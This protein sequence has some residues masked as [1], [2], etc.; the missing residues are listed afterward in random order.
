[1]LDEKGGI[2]TRLV[3]LH[4][5]ERDKVLRGQSIDEWIRLFNVKTQELDMLRM[6]TEN[7]GI[8]EVIDEVEHLS[9]TCWVRMKYDE[10]MKRIM[11]RKAEDAYVYERGME[12]GRSEGR[13]AGRIEER[14][15][16]IHLISKMNTG[17]DTD[18]IQQLNDP[19]V[20][21]AM[22]KKYRIE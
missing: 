10:H 7:V 17:G 8:L 1:M 9:L 12:Q 14:M 11:D 20:L 21:E 2:F 13:V 4:V 18:K 19:E 5:I 15:Q 6:S 16:L 3:E 22:Q